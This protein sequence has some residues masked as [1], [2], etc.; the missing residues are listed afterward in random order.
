MKNRAHRFASFW[1]SFFVGDD[2]RLAA[3]AFAALGVTVLLGV[4]WLV[5]IAVALLLT[6]S[7]RRATRPDGRR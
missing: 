6:S 4:W 1:W 7:L 3:G 2:W 5:P